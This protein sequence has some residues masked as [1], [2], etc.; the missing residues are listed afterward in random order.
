M[1]N[2]IIKK[3]NKK[4]LIFNISKKNINTNINIKYKIKI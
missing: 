2:N 1:I 4:K 3:E